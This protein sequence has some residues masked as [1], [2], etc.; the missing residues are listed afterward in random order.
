MHTTTT[1]RWRDKRG[2]YRPAGEVIDTRQYEVAAIDT[3]NVAKRFVLNHHYSGSYPSARFRFG[4]Y[5][6]DQLVGVAVFGVPMHPRVLTKHLPGEARESVELSRF[7]LFDEVPGN[8]ETWFLGQCFAALRK[9]GLVGVVS[10]SDPTPRRDAVGDQVFSGH[11]GTIYQGHNAV[12]VGRGKG[13]SLR[14]LPDGTVFSARALSKL[15]SGDRGWRYAA[16]QLEHW[17]AQPLAEGDDR[18]AWS[19]TWLDKLTRKLRH[20]GNHKYVW[21]LA[22]GARKHLPTSLPYPK[23]EIARA[24]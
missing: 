19:D 12:Y 3:D 13:R 16:S 1:Q 21:A 18:Q 8:G 24:A 11:I 2:S 10:F 23:F 22:K 17:G 6:C 15:R 20:P 5:R 14:L 4:L 9:A 7:V